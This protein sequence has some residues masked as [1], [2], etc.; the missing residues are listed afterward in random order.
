MCLA[1]R[2]KVDSSRLRGR[3]DER[4]SRAAGPPKS[5]PGKPSNEHGWADALVNTIGTWYWLFA[6][7]LATP[8]PTASAVVAQRVSLAGVAAAAPAPT[9]AT[10]AG[11]AGVANRAPTL[12]SCDWTVAHGTATATAPQASAATCPCESPTRRPARSMAVPTKLST[13][14]AKPSPNS[15]V[16]PIASSLTFAA[17]VVAAASAVSAD[18]ANSSDGA[19]VAPVAA[20][21]MTAASCVVGCAP[22]G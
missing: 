3:T 21:T 11:G 6:T 14:G 22:P 5:V 1:V 9:T 4:H 10:S 12:L 20:S 2:G 8:R 18:A 19:T 15:V 7:F 16:Q 17:A 13:V